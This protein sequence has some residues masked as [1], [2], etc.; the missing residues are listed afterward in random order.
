M[1]LLG[2]AAFVAGALAWDGPFM[3]RCERVLLVTRAGAIG[4]LAGDDEDED[5]EVI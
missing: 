3:P 2:D 1:A 5:E 4:D